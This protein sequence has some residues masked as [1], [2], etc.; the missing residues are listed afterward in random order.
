MNSKVLFGSPYGF[1]PVTSEIGMLG[2]ASRT[3]APAPAVS[4]PLMSKITAKARMTLWM[5]IPILRF[6]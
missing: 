3:M 4:C 6:L 2:R 1:I 5:W